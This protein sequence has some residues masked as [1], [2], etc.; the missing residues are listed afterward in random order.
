[1]ASGFTPTKTSKQI[2]YTPTTKQTVCV[3][4]GLIISAS[5]YRR[6]LFHGST[7]TDHC[8]LIEKYLNINV[9]PVLHTDI[10]CRKKKKKI[11]AEQM[12]LS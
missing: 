3:L 1:M 7:K 9:S 5:E 4:C 10:V 12:L 11:L 8:L 2:A 6:R